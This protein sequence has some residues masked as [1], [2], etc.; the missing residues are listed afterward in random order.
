MVAAVLHLHQGAG[1]P[2]EAVDQMRRRLAHAHDVVDDD[3]LR[4]RYAEIGRALKRAAC[5]GPGLR[6]HLLGVAEHAVDLRHGGEAFGLDL[7]GAAG[8]DDSRIRPLAPGSAD[9]L[10]RLA[11]RFGGHRAGIDHDR[12]D[13]APPP[14]ACRRMTSDS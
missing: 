8:D 11:H 1:A 4:R 3:L 5:I 6:A 7:R 10:P 14:R 13:V 9:R 2:L 12:V